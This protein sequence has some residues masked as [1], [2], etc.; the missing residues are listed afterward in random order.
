MFSDYVEDAN[1]PMFLEL[2]APEDK[3]K[4][5][6]MRVVLQN[7][8]KRYKRNK[9]VES[10]QDALDAIKEFCMRGDDDDWR[11]CLVC[12]VCWMGNQEIAVNIRQL[13]LLVDKCKSSINGAL[14]KMGYG[15][16][17]AKSAATMSLLQYIPYL[18]GNFVEQRQCTVRTKNRLSPPVAADMDAPSDGGEQ[19][20]T[21][22]PLSP[23]APEIETNGRYTHDEARKIF[24]V[25]P[26]FEIVEE[27]NFITDPCCCCPIQ[28][29]RPANDLDLF[30]SF[31]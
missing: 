23:S 29:T 14:A 25:E 30:F 21:P 18:K 7:S 1:N 16:A 5:W 31:A 28:W 4:Y 12:G 24:G 26:G 6:E 27:V 9:R 20:V 13:M 15:T 17:P 10:L 22:E 8:E 11:R 3:Q 2:L 19:P